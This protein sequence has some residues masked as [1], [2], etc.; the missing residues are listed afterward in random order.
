MRISSRETA[1]HLLVHLYS[2]KM[3]DE[4]VCLLTHQPP[5]VTAT[6]QPL[7]P[8]ITPLQP[9]LPW[10]RREAPAGQAAFAKGRL[11]GVRP[12]AV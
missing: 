2:L 6:L 9:A 4:R 10:L 1:A 11:Q 5:E 8:S 7:S 12:L 3:H